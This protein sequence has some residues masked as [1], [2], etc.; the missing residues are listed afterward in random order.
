MRHVH[1]ECIT[2]LKDN[3]IWMLHNAQGHA[4]CIDPGESSPVLTTCEA[5]GLQLVALLITHHHSDHTGGIAEL[6]AHWPSLRVYGPEDSRV[7]AT[8]R[9][10]DGDAFEELGRRFQ[11]M[12]VPGHTQSHIAFYTDGYV[13][14]G[15]TLFSLGCGRIFEG[16]ADQMQSSLE[17]FF[18]LPDSTAVCCG[19]EYTLANAAFA[20]H[21]DPENLSLQQYYK[22]IMSLRRAS[23]PTLP[24]LLSQERAANPF[25]RCDSP[26][27]Q[28]SV[29]RHYNCVFSD[30]NAVFAALRQWKDTYQPSSSP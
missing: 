28:F 27:I 5:H 6:C 13:F 12:H 19:H 3:Y 9:L 29:N 7:F 14:C 24:S 4:I 16:T 8:I 20:L 15:D 23:R 18:S 25:L 17:R 1:L 2:C 11:I 21:V 26:S 22:K 30:R 10:K